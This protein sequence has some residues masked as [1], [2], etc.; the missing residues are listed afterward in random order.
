VLFSSLACHRVRLGLENATRENPR[1][2]VLLKQ[3]LS[4]ARR[5][6]LLA[7]F[8][9]FL[10]QLKRERPSAIDAALNPNALSQ[11]PTEAEYSRHLDWHFVRRAKNDSTE[12][13]ARGW[14]VSEAQWLA[15]VVETVHAADAHP[16]GG[17]EGRPAEEAE[18]EAAVSIPVDEQQETCTLCGEA[19]EVFW[20]A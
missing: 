11:L 7:L 1:P 19:F 6:P 4:S 17:A 5:S 14:C 9:L 15:G 12:V 13:Q 3:T 18:A 16:G 2:L 8:S 20:H 10:L